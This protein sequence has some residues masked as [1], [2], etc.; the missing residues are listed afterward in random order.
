MLQYTLH[1]WH[2]WEIDLSSFIS[3]LFSDWNKQTCQDKKISNTI[4]NIVAFV[5]IIINLNISILLIIAI[6]AVIFSI[7]M[8][9]TGQWTVDA[10]QRTRSIEDAI[11]LSW[12]S[13][14]SSSSSSLSS[15]STLLPS[16]ASSYL[17]YHHHRHHNRHHHNHNLID[18]IR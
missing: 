10:G 12:S 4:V 13:S 16:S 7:S 8:S 17:M 9:V 15:S 6:I 3:N 1:L 14:S 18:K 11:K 2:F 5:V